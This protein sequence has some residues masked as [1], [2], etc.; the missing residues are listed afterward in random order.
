MLGTPLQ[1]SVDEGAQGTP[2]GVSFQGDHHLPTALTRATA[3]KLGS[4]ARL[5][6]HRILEAALTLV[7]RE[8]A[9]A[10]SMRRLGQELGVEAMSLYSYIAGRD[11]LL[12]GLSEVMVGALP[13]R[14]AEVDWRRSI[15]ALAHSIRNTAKKHPQ[16]F[17]LVGT[18]PLRTGNAL[19]P[20]DAMLSALM[21]AGLSAPEA[22]SVYRMVVSYAR[23]FA[24]AEIEGFTLDTDVSTPLATTHPSVEAA[25]ATPGALDHDMAFASGLE[26]MLAG[27]TQRYCP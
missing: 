13:R 8:G 20:V 26:T 15:Q 4:R 1:R 14:A 6:R 2:Y 17:L 5:S 3:R 9:V 22:V 10:L 21:A 24:L 16:A 12:D 11:E 27:L 7:D 18:R 23:G 19:V 25:R